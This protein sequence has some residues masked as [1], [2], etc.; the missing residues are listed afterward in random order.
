MTRDPR[1]DDTPRSGG[2]DRQRARSPSRRRLLALLALAPVPPASMVTAARLGL[3]HDPIPQLFGQF[4]ALVAAYE[5]ALARVD[6]LE[7]ALVARLGHSRVRLPTPPGDPGLYAAEAYTIER[8]LP[9]GPRARRLKRRLCQRRRSW[10]AAAEAC[11]LIEAQWHEATVAR[12]VRAVGAVLMAQ[13]ATSLA[14]VRLKL[15]VLLALYAPGGAGDAAE[16]WRGLHGLLADLAGPI[17]DHE[18][19]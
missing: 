8:H 4:E 7:A 6:R 1:A 13:T 15:V 2:E 11:G 18:R 9:P 12:A 17:A 10:E 14:G 16:P 3:C 19:D 5:R